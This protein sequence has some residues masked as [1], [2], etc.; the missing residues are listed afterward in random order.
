MYRKDRTTTSEEPRISHHPPST[1]ATVFMVSTNPDIAASTLLTMGTQDTAIAIV[2]AVLCLIIVCMIT[3]IA[4]VYAK[5]R[6]KR[7]RVLDQSMAIAI[8]DLQD[9]S[10]ENPMYGGMYAY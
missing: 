5:K 6:M 10:I 8:A 2:I 1:V 3:A 4:G 9:N 7:K